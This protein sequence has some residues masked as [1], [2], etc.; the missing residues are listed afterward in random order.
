MNC[1]KVR[2]TG[3]AL[4]RPREIKGRGRRRSIPFEMFHRLFTSVPGRSNSCKEA[5]GRLPRRIQTRGSSYGSGFGGFL[6]RFELCLGPIP[7]SALVSCFG[8]GVPGSEIHVSSA[9]ATPCITLTKFKSHITIRFFSKLRNGQ[10]RVDA[11]D[12]PVR[13]EYVPV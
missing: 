4:R 12:F 9:R 13:N 8:Q 1:A 5:R 10:A 6:S 2:F 3:V 11:W 7:G